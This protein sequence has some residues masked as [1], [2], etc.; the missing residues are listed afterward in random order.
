M[1]RVLML[2][3]RKRDLAAEESGLPCSW[4]CDVVIDEL[5]ADD[6]MSKMPR[7]PEPFARELPGWEDASALRGDL[8]G[9]QA[10]GLDG[11]L[12]FLN[13]QVIY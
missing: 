3:S 6:A 7:L 5:Q 1:L 4:L 12:D 11:L 13:R 10:S 9:V 2:C 8:T